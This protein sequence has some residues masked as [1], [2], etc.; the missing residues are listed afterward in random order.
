MERFEVDVSYCPRCETKLPVTYSETK[1]IGAGRTTI[2]RK[3][4]S[5]C[6]HVVETAEIPLAM[7]RDVL[8]DD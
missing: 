3:K 8:S 7:A 4:C 1:I 6:T 5:T 2:R